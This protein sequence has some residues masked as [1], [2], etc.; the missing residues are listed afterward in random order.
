MIF[1]CVIITLFSFLSFAIDRGDLPYDYFR[2]LWNF[3]LLGLGIFMLIRVKSKESEGFLER[4]ENKVNDLSYRIEDKK[5]EK[6]QTQLNE[7]ELRIKK[8]EKDSK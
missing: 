4:L 2:H 8:L 3:I 6:I 5:Y 1:W 7:L